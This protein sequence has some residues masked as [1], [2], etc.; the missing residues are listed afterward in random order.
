MS[1]VWHP[2]GRPVQPLDPACGILALDTVDGKK[3][4]C[5]VKCVAAHSDVL[6]PLLG[7]LLN[8]DGSIGM[9]SIPALEVEYLTVDD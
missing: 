4:E 5:N 3:L 7:R 2:N 1:K 9:C 6:L 8:E